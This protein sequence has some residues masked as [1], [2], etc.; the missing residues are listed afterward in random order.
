MYQSEAL[1]VDQD[2]SITALGDGLMIIRYLF[3]SAF[4]GAALINKAISPES[5][6]V[7]DLFPGQSFNNLSLSEQAEIAAVIGGNI[8]ALM[9]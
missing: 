4:E 9:L 7:D 2:G 8:N 1:D 5:K 3:G 6:I